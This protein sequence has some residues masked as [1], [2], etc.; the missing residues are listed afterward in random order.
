MLHWANPNLS[1][2]WT[3]KLLSGMSS[4][5]LQNWISG[6]WGKQRK[7]ILNTTSS[8]WKTHSLFWVHD[9]FRIFTLIIKYRIL[10]YIPAHL[11]QSKQQLV[12]LWIWTVV[13]EHSQS[14]FQKP[15]WLCFPHSGLP[16]DREQTWRKWRV[17]KKDPVTPKPIFVVIHFLLRVDLFFLSFICLIYPNINIG[18]KVK[19]MTLGTS[20]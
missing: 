17:S 1:R 9:F 10:K 12:F 15:G 7:A 4:N 18:W 2:N 16:K 3:A 6:R 20:L 14:N 5:C 8:F 13:G 11:N 19:K